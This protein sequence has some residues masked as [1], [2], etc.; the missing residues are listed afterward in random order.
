M[1]QTN[2][3]E[4]AVASRPAKKTRT[5]RKNQSLFALI[6]KMRL[7]PSRQGYL[8]GIREI[9]M[10]GNIATLTTHCGH[11]FT[12]N[13][14]RTS[15]ASRWLRNKS[16]IKPCKACA[17]PEWKLEKYQGTQFKKKHGAKLGSL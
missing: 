9:T 15:R 17:V 8:H 2:T 3:Q 5:Y 12:V 10:S 4:I 6:S 1:T 14:S 16:I 11:T 7:W 13:N